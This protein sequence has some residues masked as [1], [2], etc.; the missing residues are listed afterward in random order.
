MGN[1]CENEKKK[2]HFEKQKQKQTQKQ[3]EQK[4]LPVIIQILLYYT[5]HWSHL[6]DVCNLLDSLQRHYKLCEKNNVDWFFVIF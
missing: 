6:T 2:T 4:F 3:K 1:A 5:I